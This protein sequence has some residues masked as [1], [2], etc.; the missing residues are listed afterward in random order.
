MPRPTDTCCAALHSMSAPAV[1]KVSTLLDRGVITQQEAQEMRASFAG[2]QMVEWVE[3]LSA[4]SIGHTVIFHCPWCG[5]ALPQPRMPPPG[6]AGSVFINADG[7]VYSD[8]GKPVD[9]A[10]ADWLRTLLPPKDPE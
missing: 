1:E 2:A 6:P 7:T 4:Y 10:I 5:T 8:D 9:P 3:H